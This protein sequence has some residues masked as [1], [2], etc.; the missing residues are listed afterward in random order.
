M[1]SSQRRREHEIAKLRPEE[2]ERHTRVRF[3]LSKMHTSWNWKNLLK[4]I[5]A[6]ELRD[7]ESQID[8]DFN[9]AVLLSSSTKMVSPQGPTK[10]C[11][12]GDI[13]NQ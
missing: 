3:A 7:D 8:L 12:D 1:T 13:D 6:T 2:I 11:V 9:K 4:T 10:D 5:E